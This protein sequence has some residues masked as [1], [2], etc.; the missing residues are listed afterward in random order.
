M[1]DVNIYRII[2]AGSG[3]RAMSKPAPVSLLKALLD[4]ARSKSVSLCALC[5]SASALCASL[6]VTRATFDLQ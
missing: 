5:I 3:K 6:L 2:N 1:A 4:C